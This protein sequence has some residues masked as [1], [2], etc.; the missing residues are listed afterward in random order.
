MSDA[1]KCD[2]CG[3]FYTIISDDYYKRPSYAGKTI[4][5]VGTTGIDGKHLKHY[6]LCI[7]CTIKLEEF[8]MD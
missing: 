7:N 5:G 1:K 6:D 2:R 3:R 8:L 4:F